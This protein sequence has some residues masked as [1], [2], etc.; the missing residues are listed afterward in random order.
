MHVGARSSAGRA[1][2]WHADPSTRVEYVATDDGRQTIPYVRVTDANGQ[3]KEYRT[4][5]ATE[6]VVSAGTRRTMDCIDCHNTVGHPYRAD[7]REGGRSGHRR[8]RP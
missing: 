8:R 2:H 7:A 5:D 6:Q 4:A 1:I 3:V